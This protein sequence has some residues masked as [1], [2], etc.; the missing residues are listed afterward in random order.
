MVVTLNPCN[1]PQKQRIAELQRDVINSDDQMRTVLP[2]PPLREEVQ[3][4][5]HAHQSSYSIGCCY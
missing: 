3:E 1:L 2:E 5:P 4:P